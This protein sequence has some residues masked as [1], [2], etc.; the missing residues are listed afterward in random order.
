MKRDNFGNVTM[1]DE[2]LIAALDVR[3]KPF[4][5]YFPNE[6]AILSLFDCRCRLN[7]QY[8]ILLYHNTRIPLLNVENCEN[9]R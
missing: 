5:E 6:I 4:F 3:W 2:C 9:L 8:E 1:P 7:L